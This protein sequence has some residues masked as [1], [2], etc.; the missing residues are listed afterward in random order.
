[1]KRLLQW[2]R[3]WILPPRGGVRPHPPLGFDWGERRM[4]QQMMEAECRHAGRKPDQ[5]Q[6]LE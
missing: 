4:E 2:L 5:T 6:V 1:M 3:K